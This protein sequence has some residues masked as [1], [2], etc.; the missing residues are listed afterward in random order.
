MNEKEEPHALVEIWGFVFLSGEQNF[1]A[2]VTVFVKTAFYHLWQHSSHSPQR[3]RLD[4]GD[5]LSLPK[6]MS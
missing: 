2:L 3:E 1:S 4:E 6:A 5:L